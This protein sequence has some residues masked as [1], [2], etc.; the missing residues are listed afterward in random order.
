MT[1]TESNKTEFVKARNNLSNDKAVF[2]T[3]Y[4]ESEYEDMKATCYLSENK[5]SGYAIKPDGDL[6]SVFSLEAGNGMF[7]VASAIK[8]G[9]TKLDCIGKELVRFY[10]KFGF[11]E[12]D[13]WT[14][15]DE[16]APAGW[17]Y[18]QNGRPDIVLMKR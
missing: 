4:T 2:V 1:Y 6:I 9:A 15:N 16:Y 14:W 8:N 10:N 12:Y 5:K 11:R 18:E 3:P 17:D 7:I 13:R